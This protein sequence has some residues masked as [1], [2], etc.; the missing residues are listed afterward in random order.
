MAPTFPSANFGTSVTLLGSLK[1]YSDDNLC[2]VPPCVCTGLGFFY[3]HGYWSCSPTSLEAT[4]MYFKLRN[5]TNDL[6]LTSCHL[7]Y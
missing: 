7:S 6:K 3:Y 2:Y 1:K 5:K 4:I